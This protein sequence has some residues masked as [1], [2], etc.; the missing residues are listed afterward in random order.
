MG[1]RKTIIAGCATVGLLTSSMTADVQS[2]ETLN[3]ADARCLVLLVGAPPP[4]M[5]EEETAAEAMMF[6]FLVGRIDGRGG[7]T[8]LG[9]LLEEETA[10]MTPQS[11]EREAQRCQQEMK[12]KSK[13][14]EKLLRQH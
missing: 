1:R 9:D 4:D 14:F 7:N 13:E 3:R 10:K 12:G 6:W 8:E 5:S 11:A 2:V